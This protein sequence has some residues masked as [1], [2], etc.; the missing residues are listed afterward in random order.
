MPI[1]NWFAEFQ[2]DRINLSDEFRDDRPSTVVNNKNLDAVRR[3]IE[4]DS[5][6]TYH[7]IWAS[8][9]ARC[10]G[11]R[12]AGVDRA[13]AAGPPLPTAWNSSSR[14]LSI[15][16][17]LYADVRSNPCIVGVQVAG[18]ESWALHS[19]TAVKVGCDRKNV[20]V[21]SKQGRC[22]LCVRIHSEVFLKQRH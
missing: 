8:L 22:D 2:R 15:K 12:R 5:H 21:E 19:P 18:N 16:C 7:E 4:T 13:R 14:Y 6:V 20:K 17:H 9:V 11:A 3:K 1:Y 10:G